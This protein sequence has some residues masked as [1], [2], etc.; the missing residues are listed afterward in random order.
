[1]TRHSANAPPAPPRLRIPRTIWALGFVSLF[2]DLGSE[3]VHGLLP[4][5]MAGTLGASALTIGLIEGAAEALVLV[6]KVFSGYFSDAIGRRKPLVL[7]GYGMAALAKPLFPLADSIATV[8]TARLLDRFG[9]GIRGAPRDAL[10]GDL[11]P[12]SIR[13]ACFGLRQSMDTIGAVLGPLLAVALLW[14]FADNIRTVLWFAVLPGLI[15][16]ALLLTVVPEPNDGERRPARLPITRQ[17]LAHLG[18]AFWGLVAVGGLISLAR[19]S[20][21]FLVLR[22]SE[23]GVPLTFIPLVL[24]VM[25]GAY[26]LS[27]YPA[28]RLSDRL[29]RT[30]VLAAGMAVLA[31]ANIALALAEGY[32][33]LFAG[34]AL[35]G[36][37][38]GLTQ[39]ILASLIADVA[40]VEYRG[41]AFG[42]FSLVSGAG[43]LAASVLAGL[44]WDVVNPA[45]TFVAGAVVAVI[46]TVAT[47]RMS[48]PKGGTASAAD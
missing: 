20:E 41:T 1:M 28:G 31:V 19:F 2:T 30:A 5:L 17:G 25:S 44:L 36:L 12:P 43:L 6:T 40:P 48:S 29:P 16:I 35:W 3:M 46:A 7:L 9:K 10:V 23:R 15:S 27:A 26:M 37:H 47:L 14:A 18:A 33:M 13:G 34:I 24:V 4:V 8:T 38:M 22:A 45:A 32:A 39:G 42:V 11:A 21:A